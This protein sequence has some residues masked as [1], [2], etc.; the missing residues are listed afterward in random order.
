MTKK[1]PSTDI[2][3]WDDFN[4]VDLSKKR[5]TSD[6]AYQ[7]FRTRSHKQD[8]VIA[9]FQKVHGDRYDYSKVEYKNKSTHVIVI[10]SDHGE[11][12]QRPLHHWRGTGCKICSRIDNQRKKSEK[13]RRTIL[14]DF[15]KVHGDRYD[16]SKVD[17]KGSRE[18]VT[19][20][21]GEHG[22]F[23]QTPKVHKRGHGCQ[24]CGWKRS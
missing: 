18:K 7:S 6:K 10:C 11:F 12:L 14:D 21:C 20:V 17:Y 5:Y 1:K 2:E 24:K 22:E 16:Y 19:I 8:E 9:K 3:P 13:V 15:K 23:L 4:E